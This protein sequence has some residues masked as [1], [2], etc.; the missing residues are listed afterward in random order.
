MSSK[1]SENSFDISVI[2]RWFEDNSISIAIGLIVLMVLVW[3]IYWRPEVRRRKAFI[4]DSRS[5]VKGWSAVDDKE[6]NVKNDKGEVTG[7][8]T[9]RVYTDPKIRE[10]HSR[11]G[12]DEVIIQFPVRTAKDVNDTEE[13]RTY[14][15]GLYGIH[16]ASAKNPEKDGKDKLR[17]Y[18][19]RPSSLQKKSGLK[20]SW[21]SQTKKVLRQLFRLA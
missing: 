9:I 5:K 14:L 21:V 4:I 20:L 2:T 12:I 13:L 19:F 15:N 10:R 7:T 8:K 6:V 18:I 17:T 11:E 1:K 3:W 16:F